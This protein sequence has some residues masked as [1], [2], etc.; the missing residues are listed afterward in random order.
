MYSLVIPVYKNITSL[1]S[2]LQLL[3]NLNTHLDKSLEV[4]FVVDG[5]PD[6]SYAFLKSHL[7]VCA[8][9]SQLLSLSRNF[10]A[11]AAFRKGLEAARGKF[12]TVM[13][14][15]L[16]EPPELILEIFKC[17]RTEPVDVTFGIR[18][19]RKDPL[20][21]K[22]PAKFFWYFYQKFVQSD[23]PPGGIDVIGCNGHFREQLLLLNESNSSI[24][25]LAFWLG[26]KRKFITYQR[27]ERQHGKS[28][29]NF[30]KKLKYAMDSSFA[31]SDFP[32]KLLL[33]IGVVGIVTSCV[34]AVSVFIGKIYGVIQIPGYA[35]TII[36]FVFFAALNS[37]GLGII[38]SY[39]WRA[40]EN[41][42]IRPQSIVMS[43][44]E[45]N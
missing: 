34:A 5:S 18:K 15:D 20:L 35:A 12:F 13:S 44:E 23:M 2:L 45:F 9:K 1:P 32:I 26:F 14:A 19:S 36:T 40:F 3:E 4:V 37:M 33:F 17:L 39:V 38:G 11:Y 22:I 41:T 24:V 31:F 27:L 42:K 43:N 7:P 28:A 8:F 29:W 16:Q 6:D 21:H 10:G 30:G 25:G